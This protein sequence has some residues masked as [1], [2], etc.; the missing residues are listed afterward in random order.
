M[1]SRWPAH[2]HL[3]IP[4]VFVKLTKP[5]SFW[6]LKWWIAFIMFHC[7][8][9]FAT[10]IEIVLESQRIICWI[11]PS[12][13][14]LFVLIM[15]RKVSPQ[16]LCNDIPYWCWK[17]NVSTCYYFLIRARK[18]VLSILTGFFFFFL[19]WLTDLDE[20]S[21][22]ALNSCSQNCENSQGSFQCACDDGFNLQA[23]NTSC[24][25]KT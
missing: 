22:V 23:D 21:S 12:F 5:F 1:T 2:L 14:P 3:T 10:H 19:V 25:G 9:M 16:N 11:N 24:S 6:L 4:Q 17:R 7:Y 20:C 18:N 15:Q 13:L 8:K